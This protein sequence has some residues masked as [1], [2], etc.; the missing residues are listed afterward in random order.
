MNRS[1]QAQ[2]SDLPAPAILGVGLLMVA[3]VGSFDWVSTAYVSLAV[4]YI[5]P[6]AIVTW[7]LG[8]SWGLP[9]ALLCDAIALA[10]DLHSRFFA[11]FH[12]LVPYWNAGARMMMFVI[13]V[14]TLDGLRR[15]LDDQRRLAH[16]D[17]LTGVANSRSFEAMA[18]RRLEGSLEAGIP[19]SLGY[20]D[21]DDF[22]RLND[23]FGHS[24]GDR[25]LRVVADIIASGL[26]DKDFV[27]RLGG[28]EFGV[29]LPD[30]TPE[31]AAAIMDRLR[32]RIH[33]AMA[34]YGWSTTVSI[35]VAGSLP[36]GGLDE[37]VARAD[38]LMYEAKRNGKDRVAGAPPLSATG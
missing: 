30:T 16:L 34:S 22:K 28:D 2:M 31:D 24:I 33:E 19:V 8:R 36:G 10:S 37:L 4:F 6:V 12:P 3:L 23:E 14:L 9:L 17:P 1:F 35:G 11:G 32:I 26:R 13:V 7:L 38:H 15:V 5:V 18:E 25:V 21:V 27:A 20:L 29:L